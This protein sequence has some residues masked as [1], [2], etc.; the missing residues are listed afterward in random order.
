M[1]NLNPK[2]EIGKQIEEFV[3]EGYHATHQFLNKLWGGEKLEKQAYINTYVWGEVNAMLQELHVHDELGLKEAATYKYIRPDG[4][5]DLKDID[6]L[7]REK[8]ARIV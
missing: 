1:I 2:H 3:H 8:G 5:E 7:V 4:K 6:E